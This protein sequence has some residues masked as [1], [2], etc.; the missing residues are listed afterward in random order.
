M[1][2]SSIDKVQ[3][4]AISADGKYFASLDNDLPNNTLTLFQNNDTS[5]TVDGGDDGPD[6]PPG[7]FIPFGGYFLLISA[8]SVIAIIVKQKRKLI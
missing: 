1:Q 3:S 7:A 8:I 5:C 2:D 4:V 6:V